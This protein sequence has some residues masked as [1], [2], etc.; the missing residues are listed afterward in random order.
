MKNNKIGILGGMGPQASIRL[1]DLIINKTIEKFPNLKSGD[2]PEI[3]LDSIPVPDFISSKRNFKK[4]KVLLQN[5]VKKMNVFKVNTFCIACNT[6]HL[7]L[8]DLINLTNGRFVSI[9][10]EV[11]KECISKGFLRVGLFASPNSIR[12]NLYKIIEDTRVLITPSKEI[13]KRLDEFIRLTINGKITSSQKNEFNNLCRTFFQDNRLDVLILGCTE[14]PLIFKKSKSIK[15]IDTI[16]LL[17]SRIVDT[18]K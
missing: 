7:F 3:V 8:P 16:E 11:T 6:A 12:C 14:L 15:V 17:A 4:T 13:I 1:C 2:F 5:R 18:I 9:V 10:D